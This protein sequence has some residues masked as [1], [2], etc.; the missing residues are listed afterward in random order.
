[1][2]A[3]RKMTSQPAWQ[4]ADP[5]SRQAVIYLYASL[6]A[7]DELYHEMNQLLAQGGGRYPEIL[8][9]GM[10]WAP[11][12]RPFRQDPRFPDLAQRLGLIDY[13]R[14]VGPPDACTLADSGLHCT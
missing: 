8:A 13:W 6:G 5:R 12:M 3:L 7:M 4:R 1:L 2:G 11:E 9:I 10:M 14:R